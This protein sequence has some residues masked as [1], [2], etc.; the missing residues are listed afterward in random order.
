MHVCLYVCMYAFVCVY[1][2]Y[3]IGYVPCRIFKTIAAGSLA[4][5]NNPQVRSVSFMILSTIVFVLRY[6]LFRIASILFY[7]YFCII[8]SLFPSVTTSII[9]TTTP[10]SSQR[11]HCLYQ[12]QTESYTLLRIS[13]SGNHHH[14]QHHHHHC[15]HHHHRCHYYRHHHRQCFL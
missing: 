3:I 11:K 8:L 7:R 12:H 15:H 10:P 13:Y 14:Y 1:T 9:N 2:C 4:L 5:S 6:H